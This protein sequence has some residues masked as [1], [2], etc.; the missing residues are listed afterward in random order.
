MQR[1]KG[2][3][4]EYETYR[5]LKSFEKKGARFLFNVYLPKGNNETTEIDVLMI[6]QNGII[7]F[8]SKNYSGWIFGDER[9]RSWF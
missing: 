6:G 4:G 9:Y 8:E 2:R 7:V 5:L 3:L 1:D